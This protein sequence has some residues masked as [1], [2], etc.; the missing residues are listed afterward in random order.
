MNTAVTLKWRL[1][2]N[3]EC[4]RIGWTF[5]VKKKW[6]KATFLPQVLSKLTWQRFQHSCWL[7]V[8]LSILPCLWN[9][10]I[11]ECR[12]SGV[13]V[14]PLPVVHSPHDKCLWG[15]SWRHQTPSPYLPPETPRVDLKNTHTH[16]ISYFPT[17]YQTLKCQCLLFYDEKNVINQHI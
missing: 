12:W 11:L 16:F 7:H 8:L 4:S 14:I 15:T 2:R 9:L 10:F 3:A 13:W 5:F 1:C 17:P 6:W